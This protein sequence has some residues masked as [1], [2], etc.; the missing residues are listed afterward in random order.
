MTKLFRQIS[1]GLLSATAMGAFAAADTGS[2]QTVE[3]AA[4]R[5]LQAALAARQL[6]GAYAMSTGQRMTVASSGDALHVRYGRRLAKT[7][8]HDGK[9]RFVSNDGLL[10]MSFE[11][12]A[13]GQAQNV[14]LTAPAGWA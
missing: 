5:T 4:S 1:A 7:L 11:L 10:A 12:D 13:Q 8:R 14:R 2:G 9:G 3:I 6:D